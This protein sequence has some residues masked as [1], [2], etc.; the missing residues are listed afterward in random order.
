MI[1]LRN[2]LHRSVPLKGLGEDRSPGGYSKVTDQFLGTWAEVD[3]EVTG[4]LQVSPNSVCAIAVTRRV[5]RY[6]LDHEL[7]REHVTAEPVPR[8][9]PDRLAWSDPLK[10]GTVLIEV[11]V[12]P[13]AVIP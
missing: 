8:E 3:I 12:E 13:E 9:G 6:R 5:S 11:I 7:S 10:N 4:T 1:C 2:R